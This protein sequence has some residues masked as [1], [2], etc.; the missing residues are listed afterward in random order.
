[1]GGPGGQ[2]GRTH[3]GQLGV[4]ANVLAVV[5]GEGAGGEDLVEEADEEDPQRRRDQGEQVAQGGRGEV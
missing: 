2:A 3:R 1:L 5:A 4:S